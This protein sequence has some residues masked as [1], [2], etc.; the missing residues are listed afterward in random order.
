MNVECIV[1]VCP[2]QE[3][4]R[5]RGALVTGRETARRVRIVYAPGH[6]LEIDS[7]YNVI[8]EPNLE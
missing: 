1:M 5:I 8:L 6:G 7:V 4:W 2:I 3:S